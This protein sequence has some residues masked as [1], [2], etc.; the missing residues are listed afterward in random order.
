MISCKWKLRLCYKFKP[1]FLFCCWLFKLLK[2]ILRRAKNSVG[3]DCH[4]Q[5]WKHTHKQVQCHT[6]RPLNQCFRAFLLTIIVAVDFQIRCVKWCM[7]SGGLRKVGPELLWSGRGRECSVTPGAC[8]WDL[9]STVNV[10]GRGG[11]TRFSLVW[12]VEN[13]KR[14]FYICPAQNLN[15]HYSVN[16][17]YCSCVCVCV[18]V[19]I[20][21]VSVNACEPERAYLPDRFLGSHKEFNSQRNSLSSYCIW[22]TADNSAKCAHSGS[23]W[24][25]LIFYETPIKQQSTDCSHQYRTWSDWSINNLFKVFEDQTAIYKKEWCLCAWISVSFRVLVCTSASMSF[26]DW[27]FTCLLYVLSLV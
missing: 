20:V 26:S 13:R 14:P 10:V 1:L 19:P 3:S 27:M 21:H 5:Q 16:Q 9:K 22:L 8:D 15:A 7:N 24:C 2:V 4:C 23:F 17:S 25:R 12:A 18:C 6:V 11:R